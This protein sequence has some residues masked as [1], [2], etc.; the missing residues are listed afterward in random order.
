MAELSSLTITG[1]R[2]KKVL[3][4]SVQAM[5]TF[6]ESFKFEMLDGSLHH[7]AHSS[8]SAHSGSAAATGH[9][10]RFFFRFFGHHGLGR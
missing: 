6:H 1:C 2:H 7:S 9:G 5:R 3:M 8:H 4:A 10:F